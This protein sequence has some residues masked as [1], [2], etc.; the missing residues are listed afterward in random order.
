MRAICSFV[1]DDTVQLHTSSIN[2]D[3]TISIAVRVFGTRCESVFGNLKVEHKQLY[4]TTTVLVFS[5]WCATRTALASCK[6]AKV[7]VLKWCKFAILTW[8][9]I[10]PVTGV[11]RCGGP[12]GTL[13]LAKPRSIFCPYTRS[14]GG[15][16][17]QSDPSKRIIISVDSRWQPRR[18]FGAEIHVSRCCR[19]GACN[20]IN[21]VLMLFFCWCSCCVFTTKISCFG[22]VRFW[23]GLGVD[24]SILECYTNCHDC[25]H[26]TLYRVYLLAACRWFHARIDCCSM[27]WRFCPSSQCQPGDH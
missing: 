14:Q 18:V 24:H 22:C 3:A 16:P 11:R 5:M 6:F 15:Y 23:L 2:H 19:R 9:Y 4:S 26:N 7:P 21:D 27:Y 20:R 25:V 17:T 8:P 13:S 1:I 10:R 12:R